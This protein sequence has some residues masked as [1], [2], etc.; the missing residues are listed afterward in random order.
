MWTRSLAAVM[1]SLALVAVTPAQKLAL[2]LDD[3]TELIV[4]EYSIVDGRVRYFSF[5]RDQWEQVPLE[6]VDLDRTRAHNRSLQAAAE[7]RE[8]ENERERIAER[9]ARTELH[10]VPLDD[11][12]Y[13]VRGKEPVQLEQAEFDL[14][15]SMKRAFLNV[16]APVPVTTGMHTLSIKGLEAGTVTDGPKPAFYMRLEQFSRF[17][18]ARIKPEPGKGRRVVQQIYTVPRGLE[19]METQEDVE[20]FR[21]QLAPLVYKIWPVDPLPEG[22]YAVVTYT[23]GKTDLRVWDF[24]HR[25]TRSP[26]TP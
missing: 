7:A 19:Q 3:G 13:Y 4:R 11:G 14:G 17:G 24:S 23:P 25:P 1:A 10:S 21:Q 18:I 15:K 5:E 26:A 9:R 20:V 16:V 8:A 12:V 6:I 2:F 22:E